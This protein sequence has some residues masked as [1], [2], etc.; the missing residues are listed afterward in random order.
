MSTS[1]SARRADTFEPGVFAFWDWSWRVRDERGRLV[2]IWRP[3]GDTD[4]SLA[5]VMTSAEFDAIKRRAFE[6]SVLNR[7]LRTLLIAC[8]TI[9]MVGWGIDLATGRRQPGDL[10]LTLTIV[11]LVMLAL[12][13]V[14]G[15]NKHFGWSRSAAFRALREHGRCASCGYSLR[16]LCA[17][18]DG[19]R[20]T[21]PECGAVWKAGRAD[22]AAPAK[23]TAD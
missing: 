6:L 2:P 16:G 21:C 23:A 11:V 19:E 15:R 18:R 8:C 22:L 13:A 5:A 4:A 7:H 12:V 17:Q 9:M 10:F 1:E 20:V 3:R 14:R